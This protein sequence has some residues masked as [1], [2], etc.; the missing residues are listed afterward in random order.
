TIA[1]P[2]ERARLFGQDD[3]VR[4]YGRDY[5]DRL[6]EAGFD[7]SVILPGDFMTGEEIVRMGITP[8]AGEIYLCSKRAA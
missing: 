3:H 2:A 6:R 7:V 1:D 8:A 5:V 4:N